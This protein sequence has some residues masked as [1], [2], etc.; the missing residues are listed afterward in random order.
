MA[1]VFD[2]NVISNKILDIDILE[3]LLHDYGV[4]IE[5]ASRIDNWMWEN[6]KEIKFLRQIGE[7]LNEHGIV[8]IKL[9]HP[10]I[11]DLGIYIEKI[12][13]VYF[14]TVWINTEGYPMLD[15]DKITSEN[16]KYYKMIIEIVL[17]MNK[18]AINIFEVVAIGLETDI[19]YS[20]DIINMI[21]ES[22]NIIIWIL[23][24]S[25]EL[26]HELC[27]YNVRKIE[28]VKILEKI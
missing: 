10:L 18:T 22:Q 28:G 17:R 16:C 19:S 13:N 4:S 2:V 3:E 7:V 24:E 14:Y 20:K 1:I 6:E 9:K 11:K 12:E 5:S 8:I 15:C 25:I 27:G 23:N 21:K 26:N